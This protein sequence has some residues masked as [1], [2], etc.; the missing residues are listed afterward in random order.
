MATLT[1]AHAERVLRARELQTVKGRKEHG[2]FVFEGPTLLDE[3]LQSGLAIEE[4]FVTEKVLAHNAAVRELDA[5]GTPVYLIDDRTLR[6]IS[7]LDTPTGLIGVAQQRSAGLEEVLA[8]PLSLALADLN[9]PGN[10]GTLLRS[11]EAFGIGGVV[12]GRLGV[13][14]YHP[15]VV[16]GAMGA[17]FRLR[18]AVAAAH[19]FAA[20]LAAG[21]AE[22][23]GLLAEGPD[24]A[25]VPLR[26][27][28]V[29]VVGHERRGLGAWE[30][31]GMRPAGIPMHGPADS[32]NAATA[33]SIGLY[34]LAQRCQESLEG[35]KSQDFPR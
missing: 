8:A 10:V 17:L 3:A 34:V 14:P 35:S 24:L 21:G 1:G 6:K 33:G 9:D 23:I 4:L 20:A 7:D 31:P 16:R 30:T 12:L 19:E 29:L 26:T 28:A 2:R 22:A 15:K 27:P 13:D 32:L 11:A 25:S 18:I 5:R